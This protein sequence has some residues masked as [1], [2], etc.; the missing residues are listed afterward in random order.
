MDD[1]KIIEDI[2]ELTEKPE[3]NFFKNF[4]SKIVPSI[5]YD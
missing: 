4:T 1:L 2:L 3:Q 5:W